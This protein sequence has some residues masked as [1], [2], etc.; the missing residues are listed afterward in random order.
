ME[1]EK[2]ENLLID[3]I[4]GKL[5][6]TE[7]HLVD[8][9]LMRDE[10]VRKTYEQLK[11]V[12]VAM[13]C[14]TRIEPSAK[15]KLE[16]DQFLRNEITQSTKGRTKTIFFQP[17]FY[18]VAAA[19]ALVVLGGGIGFW[20]SRQQRNAA[21]LEAMR[22]EMAATK[23]MLMAMLENQQS[24]SQRVLGATVAY[25]EV[26]NADEQIINALVDAM[27]EDQNTNV[28][29]AALEALGK[30]H[31][32]P[33]VRAALI[34]SLKTQKD[35]VVQIALIRLMVEMKERSITK[36]LERISADEEILPAVKD[37]AQAGL[38]RLS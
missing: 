7:R 38:L 16:F 3:Y 13:E 19:L 35:P 23:Q 8:Q 24:A 34:A 6:E 27:N 29:L 36:D 30:F 21:E 32:Q 20:I 17:A 28:R 18:R 14:S 1:R 12:M 22:K 31:R 26:E 9:E 10:D 4:D 33:A 5:S 37:E 25:H 11:E 2:L 15:L